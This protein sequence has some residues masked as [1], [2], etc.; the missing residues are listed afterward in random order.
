[1]KGDAKCKAT[2]P[3]NHSG[4]TVLHSLKLEHTSLA[5]TPCSRG[6]EVVKPTGHKGRR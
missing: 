3:G 4:K 5:A 1:M 6:A 2:S